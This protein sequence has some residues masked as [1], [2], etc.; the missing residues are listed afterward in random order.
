MSVVRL[1]VYFCDSSV[2]TYNWRRLRAQM[3][4]LKLKEFLYAVL[5]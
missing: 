3:Y 5:W 4:V 1:S 2:L